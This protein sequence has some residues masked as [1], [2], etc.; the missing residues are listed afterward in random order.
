MSIL[1]A[2]FGHKTN[3]NTYSGG[4]YMR[5][6]ASRPVDGIS[7]I[8]ATLYATCPRCEKEYRAGQVH[9]PKDPLGTNKTNIE[10]LW[11]T[12]ATSKL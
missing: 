9:L 10:A 3:E 11:Q 1:C 5:I 7:R 6:G 2:I 4:E 8:H 12:A